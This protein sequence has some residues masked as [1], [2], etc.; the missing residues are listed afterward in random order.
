MLVHQ[1]FILG[2]ENYLH[3]MLIVQFKIPQQILLKIKN[4]FYL[5]QTIKVIIQLVKVSAHMSFM[6]QQQP[7]YQ[8][9][10]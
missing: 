2:H 8:L 1:N 3:Q 6:I 7:S 4:E 9:K 10:N 5:K